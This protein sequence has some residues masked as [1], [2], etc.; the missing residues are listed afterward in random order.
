MKSIPKNF[1]HRE[2]LS[3]TINSNKLSNL[4]SSTTEQE[5]PKG[6][7][8]TWDDGSRLGT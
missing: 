2:P 3:P 6:E 5:K 4:I 1:A 8:L 7:F